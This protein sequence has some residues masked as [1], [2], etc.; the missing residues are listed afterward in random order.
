M[1]YP[2]VFIEWQD[3]GSPPSDWLTLEEFLRE[4]VLSTCYTVG[5]LV[6]EDAH[7]IKVCQ[8]FFQDQSHLGCGIAIPK[9]WI[10]QQSCLDN[11]TGQLPSTPESHELPKGQSS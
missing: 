4:C 7:Q 6:Y 8:S 2:L 1:T 9:G 11:P 3:A 10:I 5:F